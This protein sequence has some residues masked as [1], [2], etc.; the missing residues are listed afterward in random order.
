M[1]RTIL[2]IQTNL[3]HSIA[4]SRILSRTEVIKGIDIALIQEPSCLEGHIMGLNISGCTLFW[5]GR[6]DRPRA[7]ILVRNINTWDTTRILL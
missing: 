2:F 7:C 5:R 3:Q 4:A 6:T 1:V